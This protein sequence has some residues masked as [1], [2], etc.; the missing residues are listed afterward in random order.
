MLHLFKNAVAV[1]HEMVLHI[2]KGRK[3]FQCNGGIVVATI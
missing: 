3:Q 1:R 2:A